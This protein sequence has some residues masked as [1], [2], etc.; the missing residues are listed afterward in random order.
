MGN[1]LL[2]DRIHMLVN[3]LSAPTV[4]ALLWQM[5]AR[6]PL[7]FSSYASDPVGT[8]GERSLS[9]L[10]APAPATGSKH[11]NDS[12]NHSAN[13]EA[14]GAQRPVHVDPKLFV[15]DPRF[16]EYYSALKC[17]EIHFTARCALLHLRVY[18]TLHLLLLTR[19]ATVYRTLLLIYC[20]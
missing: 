7:V 12:R 15:R 6:L 4:A 11:V 18:C 9:V 10:I 13:K 3:Q 17:L 14:S 8:G 19:P 1:A 20:M 2:A 5:Y 16:Y